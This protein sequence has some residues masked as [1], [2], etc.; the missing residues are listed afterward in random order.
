MTKEQKSKQVGVTIPKGLL[1][2]IDKEIE[3][4]EQFSSRSDYILT[5]IRVY[6][7]IGQPELR[8][9]DTIVFNTKGNETDNITF[10]NSIKK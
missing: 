6:R 5:A 3:E 10:N 1:E 9:K 7:S 2:I 8:S 4:S